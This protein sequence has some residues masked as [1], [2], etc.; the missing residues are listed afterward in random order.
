MRILLVDDETSVL[1]ALMGTLRGLDGH[2][3]RP[4]ISA[5][6][7]LA[8]AE[9]SGGVDI[10]ITDVVMEPM[11][12]FQLRDELAVRY[13]GLRAIFLTEYDLS[14]YAEM[15]GSAPVLSKPCEPETLIATI[16]SE[17]AAAAQ[18]AAAAP[19]PEPEPEPEAPPADPAV[20]VVP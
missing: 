12:G 2:E 16:R 7:A 9:A 8:N 18:P 4:A 17:V 20:Y 10:L 11:N 6:K 19:E 14:D 3:V 15:I 5:E 13:P 1:Q